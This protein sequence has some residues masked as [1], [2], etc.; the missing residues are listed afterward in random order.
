MFSTEAHGGVVPAGK[1]VTNPGARARVAVRLATAA[2][3]SPGGMT[4]GMG[5]SGGGTVTRPPAGTEA[6]RR[7]SR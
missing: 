7:V 3:A 5:E 2:S 1:A 6:P 4:G